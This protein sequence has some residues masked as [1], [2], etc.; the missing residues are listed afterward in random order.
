MTYIWSRGHRSKK[1]T[2]GLEHDELEYEGSDWH[3]EID[4]NGDTVMTWWMT[5]DVKEEEEEILLVCP[6]L[7]FG[8]WVVFIVE[9]VGRWKS[10]VAVFVLVDCYMFLGC[11][12]WHSICT[13]TFRVC[14]CVCV[15]C[16]TCA[17]IALQHPSSEV[18]C[19]SSTA[20]A[21]ESHVG[22]N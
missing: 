4:G 19:R 20:P 1:Y 18:C 3:R 12:Q 21:A 9:F 15:E 11:Q 22:W 14:V 2:T 8:F 10:I 17:R 5:V 16:L 13:D 6:F 7:L